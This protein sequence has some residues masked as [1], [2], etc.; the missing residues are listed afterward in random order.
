M[1]QSDSRILGRMSL[2]HNL[3]KTRQMRTWF[4]RVPCNMVRC[5][6]KEG[7]KSCLSLFKVVI[8]SSD[9]KIIVSCRKAQ[10]IIS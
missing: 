3:G 6:G 8:F 9:C 7:K 5:I 4:E 10:R 1:L 2:D